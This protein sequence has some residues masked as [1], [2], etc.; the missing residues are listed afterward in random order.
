MVLNISDAVCVN[1]IPSKVLL[2]NLY[3]HYPKILWM[4]DKET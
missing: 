1:L 2:K 3:I 4:D